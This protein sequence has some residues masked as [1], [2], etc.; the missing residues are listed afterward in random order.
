MKSILAKMK[1]KELKN[2]E[3]EKIDE[4]IKKTVDEFEKHPE[5]FL[6][7]ISVRDFLF[8]EI[9]SR[10]RK[11]IEDKKICIQRN[12]VVDKKP[13]NQPN[14]DIGF[15]RDNGV[16]IFAIELKFQYRVSDLSRLKKGML[17][18]VEKITTNI[19]NQ[20]QKGR[21]LYFNSFKYLDDKKEKELSTLSHRKGIQLEVYQ[22]PLKKIERMWNRWWDL[23]YD[24]EPK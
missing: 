10:L 24:R 2:N 20:K 4:S 16:R 17:K 19:K 7:E 5:L 8:R 6:S 21:V 9:V 14:F 1:T 18:D 11:E 15:R 3:L 23:E 22:L 12:M 13:G